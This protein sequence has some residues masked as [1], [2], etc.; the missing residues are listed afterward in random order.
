MRARL[1]RYYGFSDLE[2]SNMPADR[3]DRYWLAIDVLEARE[4]LLKLKISDYRIMKKHARE[5]FVSEMQR[6]AFSLGR[7]NYTSAREVQEALAK[8]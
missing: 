5:R 1:V 7:K 6:Q 2:I 4:T 8:G 3:V